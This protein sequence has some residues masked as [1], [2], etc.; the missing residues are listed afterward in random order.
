MPDAAAPAGAAGAGGAQQQQQRQHQQQQWQ[1]RPPRQPSQAQQAQAQQAQPPPQQPQQQEQ[2]GGGVAFSDVFEEHWRCC[3]CPGRSEQISNDFCMG[4]QPCT[5][6]LP[7]SAL[8][9]RLRCRWQRCQLAV[10][11]GCTA[12]CASAM[13][14]SAGLT[15]I[16]MLPRRTV[17]PAGLQSPTAAS[18]SSAQPPRSGSHPQRLL[19]PRSWCRRWRL[20]PFTWCVSDG[21][22]MAGRVAVSWP[23]CLLWP[24]P[25]SWMHCSPIPCQAD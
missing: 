24:G 18:C 15:C 6:A 25:D 19:A 2:Q 1:Q 8:P 16:C 13:P 4:E 3:P 17:R 10:I 5:A 11:A 21:W 9:C 22:C 7:N 12:R 14:P 20:Q 23:P